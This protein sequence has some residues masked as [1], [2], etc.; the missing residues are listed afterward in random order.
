VGEV[1]LLLDTHVF[2]WSK[3]NN[4]RMS[5]DAWRL[6]RDPSN[7]LF[8]SSISVVEIAIKAGIG[9]LTLG[10]SVQEFVLTGMRNAGIAEVALGCAHALRLAE[11]PAHHRD[12][13]DRMIIATAIEEDFTL[14][15]DDAE[16]RKYSIKMAW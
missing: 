3:T 1:N 9:K 13:F 4:P 12:P 5:P 15:S 10:M 8:L 14:V 11:L 7:Q 16:I 2:I 6:L